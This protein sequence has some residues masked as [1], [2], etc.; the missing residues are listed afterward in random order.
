MAKPQS[1]MGKI[2]KINNKYHMNIYNLLSTLTDVD[3]E[4]PVTDC[5]PRPNASSTPSETGWN[6]E[7]LEGT[8]I[9]GHTSANAER[10]ALLSAPGTTP[11][12]R[13]SLGRIPWLNLE[14]S[15]NAHNL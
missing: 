3:S 13:R 8:P 15:H 4:S 7:D 9:P 11:I 12:R 10:Q 2:E 1:I 5:Q 6:G 14:D